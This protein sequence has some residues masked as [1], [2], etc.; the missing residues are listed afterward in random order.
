M[1][2]VF[3][4]VC[5][6]FGSFISNSV[7]LT[8]VNTWFGKE[9]FYNWDMITIVIP[10]SFSKLIGFINII[11]SSWNYEDFH[12]ILVLN[13]FCG[14]DLRFWISDTSIKAHRFSEIAL[15]GAQQPFFIVIFC[16]KYA[17]FFQEKLSSQSLKY[18]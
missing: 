13:S 18:T 3:D 5:S 10:I 9:V 11:R 4:F 14:L 1:F 2:K 7:V 8:L 6:D 16:M 15:Y 17:L 12:S